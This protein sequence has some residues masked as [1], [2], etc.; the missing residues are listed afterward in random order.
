MLRNWNNARRCHSAALHPNLAFSLVWKKPPV[1]FIRINTDAAIFKELGTT[2]TGFVVRNSNGDCIAV[3]SNIFSGVLDPS[4]VEA[5]SIREA[6]SW[7]KKKNL[8]SVIIESDSKLVI[9]SLLSNRRNRSDVDFIVID[10]LFLCNSINDVHF[11]FC[12]RSANCAAHT[13]ARN[14]SSMSGLV[15]WDLSVPSCISSALAADKV[16]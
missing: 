16:Y 1:G 9:Q 12:K 7:V 6:L 15:Y 8:H 11:G 4:T 3:G 10:C 14:A 13:L 5:M 2:S